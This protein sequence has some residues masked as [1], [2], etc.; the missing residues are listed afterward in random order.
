[1]AAR[2]RDGLNFA[3]WAVGIPYDIVIVLAI[4]DESAML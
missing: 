4:I 3:A 2:E 1:V